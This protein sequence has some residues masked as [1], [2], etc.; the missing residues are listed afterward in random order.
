MLFNAAQISALKKTVQ[1]NRGD[2]IIVA[3]RTG[4]LIMLMIE[5]NVGKAADDMDSSLQTNIVRFG[6]Y[7]FAFS[8]HIFSSLIST[9]NLEKIKGIMT[10]QST[11]K[12]FWRILNHRQYQREIAD[13]K[14]MINHA[15]MLFQVQA[16]SFYF[17]PS[18]IEPLV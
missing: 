4:E 8:S 16:D 3:E 1:T 15:F 6:Q 7:V 2:A 9:R 13:C 12:R 14:E 17:P 10:H 5:A 18:F 11:S